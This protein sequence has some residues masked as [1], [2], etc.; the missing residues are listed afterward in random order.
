VFLGNI[1]V[2]DRDCEFLHV[3]VNF[4]CFVDMATFLSCKSNARSALCRSVL[5]HGYINILIVA[6]IC[7]WNLGRECSDCSNFH[8]KS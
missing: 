1:V 2:H 7:Y 3:D 5:V 6:N 4:L 8:L